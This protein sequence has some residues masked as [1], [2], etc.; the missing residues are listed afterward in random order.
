MLSIFAESLATQW[1]M[2]PKALAALLSDHP[3]SF[4]ELARSLLETLEKGWNR[5]EEKRLFDDL[6]RLDAYS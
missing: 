1:R 2:P 6:I 4:L 5:H 3:P